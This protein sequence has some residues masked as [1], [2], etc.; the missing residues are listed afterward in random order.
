LPQRLVIRC[1]GN[2]LPPKE[3]EFYKNLMS[4]IRCSKDIDE[5][6]YGMVLKEVSFIMK[7]FLTVIPKKLASKTG[8]AL[9]KATELYE[10]AKTYVS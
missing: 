8:I 7:I 5:N 4:A 1:K 3:E 9:N 2:Q 6:T 10:R